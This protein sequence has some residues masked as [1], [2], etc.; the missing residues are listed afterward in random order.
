MNH[1]DTSCIWKAFLMQSALPSL[2]CDRPTPVTE[3]RPVHD[4]CSRAVKLVTEVVR[5][6]GTS[7]VSTVWGT[8]YKCDFLQFIWHRFCQYE[9]K[10]HLYLPLWLTTPINIWFRISH[11]NYNF[12][13]M[14][15]SILT[16]FGLTL[17]S[18]TEITVAWYLNH[19]TNWALPRTSTKTRNANSYTKSKSYFG[20]IVISNLQH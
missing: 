18:N 2:L 6:L 4:K 13:T 15:V 7:R 3:A 14:S 16:F 11:Q 8:T 5:A 19:K 1:S 17:K 9:K 20:T 12:H 10:K